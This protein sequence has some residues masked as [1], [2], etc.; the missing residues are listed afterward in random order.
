MPVYYV[1]LLELQNIK[2]VSDKYY[3]QVRLSFE[4]DHEIYLEIDE[5]TAENLM[6]V[7]QCDGKYKYRLS[8]NSSLDITQQQ[9]VSLLT[10]TYLE[11]SN[12]ISFLCS[13][14]YT[15]I[16]T[17]IKNIQ[18]I[19][20]LDNLAFVYKSLEPIDEEHKKQELT[21]DI[22]AKKYIHKFP[23]ISIAVLSAMFLISFGYLSNIYLN[24]TV[25]NDKVLAQSIQ[26]N[27]DVDTEHIE[28]LYSTNN[29]V[30]QNVSTDQINIPFIELDETI[31]YSIEDGTVALTF[32]DGPSQYSM[33]IVDVLK[34]YE[35]GGTFFF[36][37]QNVKKYPEHIKYA[38]SNGY[39]IGS[40]SLNHIDMPTTSYANQKNELV[41]S[42]ELLE[43]ITNEEVTLF[44]PP[45]GS[46]NKHIK[47]LIHENQYKMVL[48]N[49]DPEDW[50]TRDADKIFD[51]IHNSQVSGSIILFHESQ[52]VVDA[53]PRIIEYLQQLDLK[54]VNL[55]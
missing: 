7:I 37:G 15:N 17:T 41:Q 45:Y 39:S 42:I 4:K 20:D 22:T 38:Q 27:N 52:A 10:Q 3:L 53:L 24:R 28:K 21:E 12:K 8:F 55:K 19:N 25:V 14:D 33:E 36:I 46:F 35:V 30:V 49:N 6:A 40:H 31:T 5:F 51:D 50:K 48:W 1:K 29:I 11:H 2:K 13:E 34:K 16:L 23:R 9:H 26:L 32:D 54:I 43:E 44:R 47:D 18:H